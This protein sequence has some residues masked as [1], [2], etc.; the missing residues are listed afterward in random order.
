MRALAVTLLLSLGL[1]V[2]CFG[3][4]DADKDEAAQASE[5]TQA[6]TP[7]YANPT[8]A[9]RGKAEAQAR[10]AEEAA[11]RDAAVTKAATGDLNRTQAAARKLGATLKRTLLEAMQEKGPAG[12]AEFCSTDAASL[13]SGVTEDTGVRV[14]RS[15][16]RLRNPKNVAPDW[17]AAWLDAQGETVAKGVSGIDRL[18]TLPDGSTVA[19]VLRPLP[20][21]A[22]CLVCHG[23]VESIPPDVRDLLAAKYPDDA[24]TGYALGDLR[25]ALWAE[26]T[27]TPPTK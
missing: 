25:G 13:T 9:A 17:V 4:K 16:L 23:P 6:P 5:P 11:S 12:A 7:A 18:D 2:G 10:A 1:L 21:G 3:S 20:V 19:R 26:S 14:G 15:S 27:V 24:A 22:P 8:A